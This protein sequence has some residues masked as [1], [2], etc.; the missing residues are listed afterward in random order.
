MCGGGGSD[1]SAAIAR[2]AERKRQ[3]RISD[4]SLRVDDAFKG[5]ND[6]F[7]KGV[8]DDYN[9]HYTPLLEEQYADA[10]KNAT[11]RL[12]DQGGIDSSAGA[13]LMADLFEKYQNQRNDISQQAVNASTQQ[14][15]S[16]ASDRANLVAQLE[17]G[18]SVQSAANNAINSANSL[19]DYGNNYQSL[20]NIFA[21]SIDNYNTY[22]RGANLATRSTTRNNVNNYSGNN[23]SG[24]ARGNGRVVN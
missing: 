4:G 12:A 3:I 19:N 10:Q 6:S 14:K 5:F 15:S 22:N 21:D 16:V 11:F 17:A 1:N 9:A 23:S 13:K 20:E 2:E 8:S 18:G 7:Y 24:N